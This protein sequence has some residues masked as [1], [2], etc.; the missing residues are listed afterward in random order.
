MSENEVL[1]VIEDIADRLC[2]KY[3]FGPFTS[4][5]IRQQV[6]L[7]AIEALAR[8]RPER[9][10]L[11]NFLAR[12]CRNRLLNMRRCLLT[13]W[14]DLPCERCHAG[15][16]CGKDGEFCEPYKRWRDR[17]R[18]KTN[19]LLTCDLAE[20]N[21]ESESRMRLASTVQAD[22]EVTEIVQLLD[23]R[24]PVELRR[25]MLQIRAGVKVPKYERTR[26]EEAVRDILS[27]AG[28]EL[29]LVSH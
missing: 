11:Q 23:E 27:D 10:A 25:T 7:E 13:R 4:E 29:D 22:A 3:A 16:C 15:E 8:F 2:R 9:G 28:V 24:L 20:V 21:D 5:D 6:A 17:N 18:T 12:H 14:E 26:V 1:D 19:L